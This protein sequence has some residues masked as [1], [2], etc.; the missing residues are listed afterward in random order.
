LAI[1]I[2]IDTILLSLAIVV[3]FSIYIKKNLTVHLFIASSR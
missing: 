1:D 3:K 2:E